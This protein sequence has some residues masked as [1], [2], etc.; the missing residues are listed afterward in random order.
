MNERVYLH[1]TIDI[2]GQNRAAYNHHMTANYGHIAR[3]ERRLLCVGV[4]S[5]VGSTERWPQSTNIWEFEDGWPGVARNFRHEF[6]NTE[7]QDKNLKPWWKE[8][9]GYRSG[10]Y[11]RLLVP[12]AWSPTLQ[13]LLDDGVRGECYYHEQVALEPGAARRFL[14]LVH[15]HRLALADQFGWRLVLAS[16]TS[17]VHDSEAILVWAVPTWEDWARWEEAE[18][19]DPAVA[20]WRGQISGVV[21]DWRHKLL[22]ASELSP[23]ATGHLL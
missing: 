15:D 4:F 7:H 11:D 22:V 20:H 8:A 13:H 1:E 17:M 18:V 21:R 14:E 3:E 16:R 23:L 5:T 19:D 10:G 9:S 12:A 6:S 2:I